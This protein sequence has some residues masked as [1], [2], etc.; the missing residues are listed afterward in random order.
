MMGPIVYTVHS[1]RT[2]FKITLMEVAENFS[3]NLY[4]GQRK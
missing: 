2:T 4:H 1:L 3:W